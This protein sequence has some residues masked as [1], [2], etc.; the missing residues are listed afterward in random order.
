MSDIIPLEVSLIDQLRVYTLQ[1]ILWIIAKALYS[2]EM[3]V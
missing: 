1:G 3:I 2:R